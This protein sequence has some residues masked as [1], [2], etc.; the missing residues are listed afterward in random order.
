MKENREALAKLIQSK[1]RV[2]PLPSQWDELWRMLLASCPDESEQQL[3]T[4]LILGGWWSTT[5]EQKRSRLLEH[6]NW[7]ERLNI[8][9]EVG[10][11]LRRLRDDEWLSNS[12]PMDK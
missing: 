10:K 3:P 11:F 2:C 8:L 12:Y 7:A 4:P 6:L 9:A 5:D 1:Q